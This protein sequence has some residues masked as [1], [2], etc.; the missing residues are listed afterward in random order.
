M[1]GVWLVSRLDGQAVW[2]PDVGP[3]CWPETMPEFERAVWR[4]KIAV[5]RGIHVP[6][7]PCCER[8]R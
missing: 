7:C 6:G 8:R 1:S 4:Q 2:L 5:E 3:V